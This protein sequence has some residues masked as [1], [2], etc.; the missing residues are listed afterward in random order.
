MCANTASADEQ[1]AVDEFLERPAQCQARHPPVLREEQ[2]VL[3][4]VTTSK[5]TVTDRTLEL[6]RDLVVER[7]RTIAIQLDMN[8]RDPF[9]H[10]HNGTAPG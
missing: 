10:R 6:S 5:P 7:D 8:P 9:L 3:E 4:E 2:L 1:S